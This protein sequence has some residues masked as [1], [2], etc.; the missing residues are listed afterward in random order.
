MSGFAQ[1]RGWGSIRHRRKIINASMTYANRAIMMYTSLWWVK[2]EEEETAL[3]ICASRDKTV[4][5][6]DM[7]FPNL[8]CPLEGTC[9][10]L[11]CCCK[12]VLNRIA[13]ECC[14]CIWKVC[15]TVK[16]IAEE[17]L[18]GSFQEQHNDAELVDGG[19]LYCCYTPVVAYTAAARFASNEFVLPP[20]IEICHKIRARR[21]HTHKCSYK[22]G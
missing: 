19:G 15:Q 6:A 2:V 12:W 22:A 14:C 1:L 3:F 4:S 18:R 8:L 9:A 21:A 5:V 7:N 13:E 16:C 17:E 10:R 11:C 20:L